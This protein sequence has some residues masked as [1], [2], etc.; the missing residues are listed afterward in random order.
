MDSLRRAKQI[1]GTHYDFT[2]EGRK[3]AAHPDHSALLV[4]TET[5]CYGVP[6]VI[7]I[8][9]YSEPGNALGQTM[10]EVTYKYTLKSLAPWVNNASLVR[11]FPEV[12]RIPIPDHPG[13]QQLTLVLMSD[14]W[15]VA[16]LGF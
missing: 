2:A 3:Y 15:R 4:G 9:R 6:E 12:A 16:N 7:D 10:T 11:Q 14:G 5:L 13:E 8:V 1:Q